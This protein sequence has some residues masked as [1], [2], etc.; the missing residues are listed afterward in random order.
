MKH[1]LCLIAA[2]AF[3]FCCNPVYSAS[4]STSESK[5]TRFV[6]DGDT[7]IVFYDLPSRRF[8]ALQQAFINQNTEQFD[9]D[10]EVTIQYLAAEKS[11]MDPRLQAPIDQTIESLRAFPSTSDLSLSDMQQ[12][13]ARVHWL[14]A[15]HFLQIAHRQTQSTETAETWLYYTATAHHLERAVLWASLE[16]DKTLT[17]NL[18]SLRAVTSATMHKRN[19]DKRQRT[20]QRT[21]QTLKKL[22]TELELPLRVKLEAASDRN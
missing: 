11:R 5:S 15:Q 1:T 12:H 6:M 14:L 19:K 13:F 8:R 22:S 10:L 2:F 7:F 4:A 21:A 9:R 17:A 18:D 16:I 3:I 20:L